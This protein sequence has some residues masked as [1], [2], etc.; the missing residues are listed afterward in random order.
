MILREEVCDIFQAGSQ[1][2]VCPVNCVGVMGAGLAKSMSKRVPG[3][4]GAYRRALQ[5]GSLGL[6][7]PWMYSDHGWNILCFATKDHWRNESDIDWIR[8]GL[9]YIKQHYVDLGI[10]SMAISPI[11][12]GLGGLDWNKEV[13]PLVY[14]YLNPLFYMDTVI[15]LPLP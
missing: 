11:G 12:C 14:E 3:L 15:C 5:A 8:S 2:L 6:G 1:V 9:A 4:E 13:R 10:R 7:K